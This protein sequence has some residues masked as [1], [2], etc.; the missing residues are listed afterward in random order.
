MTRVGFVGLGSQGAPMARRIVD[1]GFRT[2]LWAR[3]PASL[4]PFA[5]TAATIAATPAELGAASDV[6]CVCVVDDADVDEVLRGPDGALAAMREGSTVV[7]HSTVHPAT[8]IRLQHDF[9]AIK[10]VDAPVSGGGFKAEARELLVMVGGPPDVVEPC[11]PVFETYGNPVLHVGPLGA[12]QEAKVLNNTVFTAQLALAAEVFEL[13]AARQLDQSAIAT[14]LASGSGRSYAAEIVTGGGFKLDGLSPVAGALLAKDVGILVDHA[15]LSEST[16]VA[17]ADADL[18][19][20]G[21]ARPAPAED[22]S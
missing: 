2:T 4:E 5:E 20:M 21:V 8:C 16:L 14:I 7:V 13:A 11:R 19:R 12:G 9:P 3:R 15:A 10:V 18:A 1:A 17:A 22:R 6:L